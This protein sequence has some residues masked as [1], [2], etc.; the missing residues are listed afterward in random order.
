MDRKYKTI[1][2]FDHMGWG[3]MGDAAIHESFIANITKRQPG[4]QLVAFSLYPD[5]TRQRH[6]LPCYPIRW[7]Y[8]GSKAPVVEAADTS[9]T[10]R[11][12]RSFVKSNPTLYALGKPIYS[13]LQ[14]LA[15]LIRS[16]GVVRSL[17]LL[18]I[19]GGGQLCELHGELPY[20]VFKFCLLARL[21]R[22][23]VYIVG[24]G[25]DLLKRSANRFFARWAV[26]M[27]NYV[28]FRSVESKA[29]VRGLGVHKVLHVCPDPAYGLDYRVYLSSKSSVR[30]APT[31]AGALFRELGI[32]VQRRF[33]PRPAVPADTSE[34]HLQRLPDAA[35]LKVGLNPISYCDPRR[36]PR[37]DAAVYERYLRELTIFSSWLLAQN[38]HVEIFTSDVM[39]VYALEDVRNRLLTGDTPAVAA[40][41]SFRPV[42]TL[43]DLFAQMSTFD[44]VV[45]SKYH[46]VIFSHLLGKPVIALSYLPKINDLMRTVGHDHY[47]LNIE[48]IHAGWLIERFQRLVRDTNEL[49]SL[50][51]KTAD[52]YA[53][54]LRV[55]FDKLFLMDNSPPPHQEHDETAALRQG[56]EDTIL[57]AT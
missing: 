38:Y 37:K 11:T 42:L 6:G 43:R 44:F 57:T 28:S 18:V 53:D 29:L 15:H 47:C 41:L 24:V 25:A 19:A 35:T 12:F 8:P 49:K 21:A 27:A 45:T 10:K 14:E 30:L 2:L 13:L 16:Y 33:A 4:T 46:G 3:N 31:Q 54:A 34:H 56:K 50:F 23:P 51:R 26:R 36:W 40:K 20:N 17:D 9:G 22:T 32:D 52:A 39:D 48:H 5:D 1:G 7:W 55:E